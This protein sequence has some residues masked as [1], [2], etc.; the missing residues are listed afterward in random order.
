MFDIN[1]VYSCLENLI[2]FDKPSD[3][4]IQ[5]DSSLLASSSGFSYSDFHPLAKTESLYQVSPDFNNLNAKIAIWDI[6]TNYVVNDKVQYSGTLYKCLVDNVGL[7]PDANPTEWLDMGLLGTF[8]EWLNEFK[9]KHTKAAIQRFFEKQKAEELV[10]SLWQSEP[11]YKGLG[12]YTDVITNVNDFVGFE[13]T[14]Q[15]E[16]NLKL[17]IPEVGTQFNGVTAPFDLTIYLF[18]SSQYDAIATQTV[19]I[20]KNISSEWHTLSNSFAM[21]FEAPEYNSGG[22]FY[23]GYKQSDLPGSVQAINRNFDPTKPC[24]Q[25]ANKYGYHFHKQ[26]SPFYTI[27]NFNVA[28]SATDNLFVVSDIQY[29]H[30]VNYGLNFKSSLYCD[31]SDFICS[32]KDLI[33]RYLGLYVAKAI[34]QECINTL[35]VNPDKNQLFQLAL[36]D[37]QNENGI[38]KELKEAFKALRFDFSSLNSICLPCTKKNNNIKYGSY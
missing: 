12:R 18:H 2:G 7:Q 9:E 37:M 23:L 38:S 8:D 13:I 1:T 25:C 28:E 17:V 4:C 5:I 14:L 35:R 30:K 34:L 11:L 27:R 32:Q 21:F 24:Y 33:V 31:L 22:V 19:S 15:K 6:A 10:K 3:P 36:T 29:P 20:T 16:R 26:Y